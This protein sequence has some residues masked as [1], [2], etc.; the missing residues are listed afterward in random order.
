MSF[1]AMNPQNRVVGTD[2]ANFAANL[3]V[4]PVMVVPAHKITITGFSVVTTTAFGPADAPTN[5]KAY[6]INIAAPTTP[7]AYLW[8]NSSNP[9]TVNTKFAAN[10]NTSLSNVAANTILA[11][12]MNASNITNAV[13]GTK[14]M[15]Q[16]DYVQGSPASEG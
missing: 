8:A 10:I 4:T 7:I 3:A 14:G 5:I 6:L 11:I 16:I 12:Y 2:L 13:W 9:V 1:P 15:Y